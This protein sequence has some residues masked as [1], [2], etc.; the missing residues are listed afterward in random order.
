MIK[1][2][3]TVVGLC[4]EERHAFHIRAESAKV[5]ERKA[6]EDHDGETTYTL[7]V[8]G[9]FSGKLKAVDT[10]DSG[11][12]AQSLAAIERREVQEADLGDDLEANLEEMPQVDEEGLTKALKLKP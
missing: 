5:A 1:H 7:F 12:A 2:W 10:F 4:E 3:Y 11:T 9:V 8:A 6:K